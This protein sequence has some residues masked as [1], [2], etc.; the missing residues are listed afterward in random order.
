MRGWGTA[1]WQSLELILKVV[2]RHC[3]ATVVKKGLCQREKW[4]LWVFRI[5]SKQVVS[6]LTRG[7]RAWRYIW[8]EK[9]KLLIFYTGGKG[10]SRRW[11]L[12]DDKTSSWLFSLHQ[13]SEPSVSV[14]DPPSRL[15]CSSEFKAPPCVWSRRNCTIENARRFSTAIFHLETTGE[16][17]NSS[18]TS[19][20]VIL[21]VLIEW[22]FI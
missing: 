4:H 18:H 14:V 13:R 11:I 5:R 22:S 15:S 1:R 19:I 12:F 21:V 20:A 2:S 3:M 9:F 7:L 8:S 16:K 17:H 10:R 6:V